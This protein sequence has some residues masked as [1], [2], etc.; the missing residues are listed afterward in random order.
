M[1]VLTAGV[2]IGASSRPAPG[3][4]HLCR[5]GATTGIHVRRKYHAAKRLARIGMRVQ[6]SPT[7][8]KASCALTQVA[9]F[10][11]VVSL[12][13]SRENARSSPPVSFIMRRTPFIGNSRPRASWAGSFHPLKSKKLHLKAAWP[14]KVQTTC[15][16][17]GLPI[18]T[19][20][21]A[22]LAGQDKEHPGRNWAIALTTPNTRSVRMSI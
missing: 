6:F 20:R 9:S 17:N 3:V 19:P 16:P 4:P 2:R 21:F 7:P 10:V 1:A 5:P 18:V 13:Q 12:S 14:P 8:T 15:N 22:A 11:G